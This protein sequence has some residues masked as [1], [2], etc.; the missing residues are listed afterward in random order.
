MKNHSNSTYNVKDNSLTIKK[1][2]G[3]ES[4]EVYSEGMDDPAPYIYYSCFGK[5]H[6]PWAINCTNANVATINKLCYLIRV[7]A[8]CMEIEGK[9]IYYNWTKLRSKKHM[10]ERLSNLERLLNKGA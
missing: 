7:E 10:L 3:L 1:L 5:E 8:M 2:M 6:K 4:I 9:P